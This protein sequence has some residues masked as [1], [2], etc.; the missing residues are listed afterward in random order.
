MLA[1]NLTVLVG[2]TIGSGLAHTTAQASSGRFE[3]LP[4]RT[5][6]LGATVPSMRVSYLS[7]QA[8]GGEGAA[9][10]DEEPGALVLGVRAASQ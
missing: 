9:E 2:G 6:A 5:R 3:L 8:E 1:P 10:L 4:T 7:G